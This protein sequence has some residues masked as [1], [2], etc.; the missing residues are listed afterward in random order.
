MY[1]DPGSTEYP[2][3][4]GWYNNIGRPEIGA[5]DTP[6]LRRWP[7]AYKDGAY[8]PSGFNRPN[9]LKISKELLSGEIGSE[10]DK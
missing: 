2:G 8:K 1:H 5:V 7:A 9:P 4:D 10:S 6:L 3:Y